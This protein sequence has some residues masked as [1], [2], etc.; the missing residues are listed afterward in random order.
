MTLPT[1]SIGSIPRPPALLEGIAQFKQ[2][3]LSRD[4]LDVLYEAA[5]KDTI[6]RL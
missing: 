4:K 3:K 5:L 2:G 6:A 1:E